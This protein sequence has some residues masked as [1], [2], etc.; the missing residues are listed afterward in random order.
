MG[1]VGGG[2]EG[3]RGE[4]VGW[5]Y[6]E[7]RICKH[8]SY[9]WG[10]SSPCRSKS[11]YI[12]IN[13]SSACTTHSCPLLSWFST[14]QKA[15]RVQRS[16]RALSPCTVCLEHCSSQYL[17][18]VSLALVSPRPLR[19]FPDASPDLAKLIS[20][21]HFRL[22]RQFRFYRVSGRFTGLLK[23]FWTVGFS[24]RFFEFVSLQF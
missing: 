21:F 7:K 19:V 11:R 3:F 12:N 10:S 20:S 4:R 18:S 9:P 22:F 2:R 23:F 16:L 5:G 24:D 6:I 14:S 8:T 17:R 15:L 1:N 13:A